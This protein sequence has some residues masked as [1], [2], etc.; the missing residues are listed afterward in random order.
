M[1]QKRYNFQQLSESNRALNSEL[2]RAAERVIDSGRYLLGEECREFER[3]FAE[4]LGTEYAV[5]TANGLEAI[6]LIFRGLME[7]GELKEGD[8]VAVAAN[9]FIASILPLSQL[10]LV[11][12][13]VEPDYETMSVS[14]S[15][16]AASANAKTKAVLAVHLYGYPTFDNAGLKA[17]RDKGLLIV[18]DNAQ[19]IGAEVFD[20]EQGIWRNCGSLGDASATSFYPAKNIGALGDAGAVATSRKEL[21]EVVRELSNYGGSRKY[22][23]DYQGYNSRLDELQA[24]ML[25]VKLPYAKAERNKRAAAARIYSDMISHPEIILPPENEDFRQAWH[26]YVVRT[27]RREELR[28]YLEDNGVETMIHYPI[29]PHKQRC[30]AGTFKDS[31]PV[32]EQLSEEVLSLPIANISEADAKDISLIINRFK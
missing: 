17:L 13:L 23:Y 1:N 22:H 28:K 18:E 21:A 8:G 26:Q 25:R 27:S 3:E 5:G 31:Y 7:L 29:P 20:R 24:A 16:L 10:G 30:Y 14:F 19:A 2:K 32:A 9:T 11:P 15:R 4:A 6:R 12:Q